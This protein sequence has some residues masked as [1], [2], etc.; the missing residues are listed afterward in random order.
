VNQ[1]D[2]SKVF[3][4]A[5]LKV[6]TSQNFSKYIPIFTFV[7]RTRI[8]YDQESLHDEFPRDT[9]R[10]NDYSNRQNLRAIYQPKRVACQR[11]NQTTVSLLPFVSTAFNRISHILSS[12]IKSVGLPPRKIARLL[13][14]VTEDLRLKTP[15]VYSIPCE[16][17][18]IYIGQTGR[19]VENRVKEHYG[20]L[21]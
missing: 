12:Y 14:P 20:T 6:E 4:S 8:L 7:H 21:V 3:A 1:Y 5:Y 2:I 19:S 18:Q 11:R 10:Q 17:G 9:F 15:G 13:P 16:C